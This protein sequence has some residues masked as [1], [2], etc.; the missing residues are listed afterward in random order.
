MEVKPNFFIVGA[1][2]CGTTALYR[3][4]RLHPNIYMPAKKEPHFFARDLGSY[5]AIQ[6]MEDYS[7]LF[8]GAEPRHRRIGEASVYYLRSEVAVPNILAYNPEARIIA[9]FRNPVDMVYSFHSQL[10]YWSEEVV[11]DFETAWRLQEPRSRGIDLPRGSRGAFLLQYREMARFGTQAQR[12]L[13]AAP[14]QQVKLILYDD[15]AASPRQRYNEVVEFLGLPPDG[16]SEF[17]RINDNKRARVAWL[18]NLI[19]KPPPALREAYR[20][21]KSRVGRKR[22]DAIRQGVLERLTVK[23]RR[24]PLSPAFRAELVEVFRDEVALLGRLLGRD[25]GHW[26]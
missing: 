2:K 20:G 19:R 1:P 21:V 13:S 11:N 16:R 7:A 22:L 25:L 3:Y 24:E 5:P 23:E 26:E 12:L 18:R 4:L 15:F 9:M 14:A 8:M 10:L 6:T 17:P